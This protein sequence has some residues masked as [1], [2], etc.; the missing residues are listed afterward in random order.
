MIH[1][2]NLEEFDEVYSNTCEI[3]AC[4]GDHQWVYT[5]DEDTYIC[6]SC[7]HMVEAWELEWENQDFDDEYDQ[8][9]QA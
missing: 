1:L 2:Q 3:K 9:A 7:L 8:V 6:Q 4:D 5:K